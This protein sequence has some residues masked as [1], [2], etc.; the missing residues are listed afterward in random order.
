MKILL[1]IY[2]GSALLAPFQINAHTHKTSTHH[3]LC[4]P[5]KF[6]LQ[7]L[8]CTQVPGVCQHKEYTLHQCGW[9]LYRSGPVVFGGSTIFLSTFWSTAYV[10]SRPVC[11]A[12]FR[13]RMASTYKWARETADSSYIAEKYSKYRCV[14]HNQ[15]CRLFQWFLCLP[16]PSLLQTIIAAL[17]IWVGD[18]VPQPKWDVWLA[19]C[20]TKKS[21]HNFCLRVG[22]GRE[23]HSA[24][25]PFVVFM[26]A[27]LYL[28]PPFLYFMGSGQN[29]GEETPI[30]PV[31]WCITGNRIF[32][33]FSD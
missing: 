2:I 24:A 30:T 8:W 9:S 12:A 16:T 11:E 7:Y 22:W 19:D 5:G 1:I 27:S 10:L 25:L 29:E 18:E 20:W 4:K 15:W 17:E 33:F 3:R 14:A 13:Q 6:S 28:L 32:R 31:C 21:Y 26:I 23:S